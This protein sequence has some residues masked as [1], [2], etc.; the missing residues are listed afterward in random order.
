MPS[1]YKFDE[2]S[3]SSTEPDISSIEIKSPSGRPLSM[4][5]PTN[6]IQLFN[7]SEPFLASRNSPV[8]NN[9][10]HIQSFDDYL[11]SSDIID[12]INI[13]NMFLL[14]SVDQ[15]VIDAFLMM[16]KVTI[17][18]KK[19]CTL[20]EIRIIHMKW[21]QLII[22]LDYNILKIMTI[23]AFGKVRIIYWMMN[24]IIL[25]EIN[26]L[27]ELKILLLAFLILVHTCIICF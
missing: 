22:K 10:I 17:S 11:P 4:S 15:K 27:K 9:D 6:H 14:V 25:L 3:D 21:L 18:A 5:K 23:G 2:T 8:H 13:Q 16:W 24:L 19:C 12:L 20:K 1:H 26:L 7:I